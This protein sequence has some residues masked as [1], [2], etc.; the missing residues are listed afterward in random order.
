MATEDQHDI[1]VVGCGN[2]G[3][4][5]A[6]RLSEVPTMKVLVLEAGDDHAANPMVQVPAGG[7]ALWSD[8]SINWGF[9]TVPQVSMPSEAFLTELFFFANN[10]ILRLRKTMKVGKLSIPAAKA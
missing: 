10:S 9:K 2:A 3:S 6:A 1:I 4:V 8:T 7:M 5:L